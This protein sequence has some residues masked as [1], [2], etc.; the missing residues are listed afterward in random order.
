[1]INLGLHTKPAD[2]SKQ[3]VVSAF[4]RSHYR[5]FENHPSQ[6]ASGLLGSAHRQEFHRRAE[7]LGVKALHRS[8]LSGKGRDIEGLSLKPPE[9]AVVLYLDEICRFRL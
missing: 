2:G 5:N 4:S 9:K 8:V 6:L 1:M 3:P 7:A